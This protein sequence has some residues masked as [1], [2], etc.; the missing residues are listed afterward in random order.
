MCVADTGRML[1]D[2]IVL[3]DDFSIVRGWPGHDVRRP[4]MVE[5]LVETEVT[6][7]VQDGHGTGQDLG[8]MVTGMMVTL[9][10][11][12]FGCKRPADRKSHRDQQS[13]NEHRSLHEDYC[14]VIS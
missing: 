5:Q 12:L 9:G 7:V 1:S 4:G 11:G 13:E 10:V 2:R 3:V 6:G 14:L 8:G